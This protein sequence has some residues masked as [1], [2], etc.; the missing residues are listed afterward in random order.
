[1]PKKKKIKGET[2]NKRCL[3]ACFFFFCWA[4]ANQKRKVMT[5]MYM[6]TCVYILYICISWGAVVRVCAR[7]FELLF[8]CFYFAFALPPRARVC[9]FVFFGLP[10]SP[11]ALPEVYKKIITPVCLLSGSLKNA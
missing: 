10:A 1:M 11:L 6:Y 5:G 2:K 7:I 9:V 4:E 8:V 3:L